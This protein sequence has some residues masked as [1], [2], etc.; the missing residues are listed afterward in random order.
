[1]LVRQLEDELRQRIRQPNIEMQQ[2]VE[3]MYAENE[4]L[5]RE[6]AIL[7]DTIKVEKKKRIYEKYLFSAPFFYNFCN[8][9]LK[10][11]YTS[12]KLKNLGQ[13]LKGCKNRE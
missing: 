8:F 11:I 3:G 7:R 9:L 10:F 4:H 12:L 2:Q 5:T 13:L 6:I 1:M